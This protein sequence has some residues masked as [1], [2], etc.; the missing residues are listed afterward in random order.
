MFFVNP[1]SHS[2]QTFLLLYNNNNNTRYL[3]HLKNVFILI[4]KNA[5]LNDSVNVGLYF[6]NQRL[7]CTCIRIKNVKNLL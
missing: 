5:L 1:I 4:K 3:L 6:S 2:R 7:V